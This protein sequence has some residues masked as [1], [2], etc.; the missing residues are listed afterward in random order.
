MTHTDPQ[1][2]L[3]VD[4]DKD[5]LDLLRLEFEV[6][7]YEVA[8]F[9]DG[10]QVLKHVRKSGLPHLALIDLKLPSM[11]G[12]ELA[13]QL[14][15][16]GDV[17]IVFLTSINEPDTIVDG[18][19]LYADDYVTKPFEIRELLARVQ[20]VLSRI[21]DFRYAQA[22]MIEVDE[23]LAVDFGNSRLLVRGR[24]VALTP[25]EASLLHVLI[26]NAGRVVPSSTLI[27]RVWPRSEIYE[28]TLR[29]HMHRLRR[30]LEPDFHRPMYVYTER[31]VGYRFRSLE[32]EPDDPDLSETYFQ[33]H[34]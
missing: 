28:D 8:T 7:G 1:K 9:Q 29:V 21:T 31:G 17:P 4:D 22:P 23:H 32:P 10:L 25:T 15:S 30:K 2:I 18:L 14:K 34:T 19:R 12:F 24:T 6:E 20:R 26:R 27:A 5:L 13:E 33:S 11:H 3:L 16:L